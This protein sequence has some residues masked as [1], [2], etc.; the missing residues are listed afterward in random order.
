MELEKEIVT[1]FKEHKVIFKTMLTGA[2]REEVESAESRLIETRD[3][4]EFSVKDMGAIVTASKHALL[5]ASLV[6]VDGDEANCFERVRKMYDI[7]YNFIFEQVEETQKK[8]ME[9][10]ASKQSS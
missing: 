3:G 9:D 7:D 4:K 1:P 5:K 8:M 2:E 6:S 10:L